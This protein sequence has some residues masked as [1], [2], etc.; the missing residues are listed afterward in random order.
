MASYNYLQTY[1]VEEARRGR[2]IK[3]IVFTGLACAFVALVAYLIFHNFPERQKA[4][5]FL[6]D[7]NAHNYKAAYT[8]WGCTDKTPCPNYDMRRF[9]EDWGPSSAKGPW[10]VAS[11]DSCKTFLT[12]NVQAPGAELQS[13]AVQRADHSLSF[14]PSPECQERQ[15]RWKQFFHRMFGGGAAPPPPSSSH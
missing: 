9:M 6:A 1:G 7:I 5:Q 11:T 4:K 2:V 10:S 15:W 12:I 8:E 13:I 14:A 3:A